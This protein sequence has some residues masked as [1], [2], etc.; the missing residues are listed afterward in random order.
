[1]PDNLRLSELWRWLLFF[2]HSVVSYSL[3]PPWTAARQASL[4][5]TISW[6]LLKLK[7]I[8]SVMPSNHPILSPPSPVLT[9]SQHHGLFQWIG[10]LQQMA[11]VLELQLKH[12]HGS[13]RNWQRLAWSGGW[14][15][16]CK[17]S[18]KALSIWIS[19]RR[20]WR[21]LGKLREKE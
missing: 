9:L 8:E 19:D 4:S 3:R 14:K 7:S 12:Q 15:G 20:G 1:M 10:S 13:S 21:G 16:Y 2:S 17:V 6:S 11:K 5:F 18:W